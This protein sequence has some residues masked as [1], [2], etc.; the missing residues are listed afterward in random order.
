M[1]QLHDLGLV[2]FLYTISLESI[3]GRHLP[4]A[5]LELNLLGVD[6]LLP[7]PWIIGLQRAGDL[8]QHIGTAI[9]R[10]SASDVENS[11]NDWRF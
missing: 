3:R 6:H 2:L 5:G 11:L 1:Q 9:F 10:K 4:F 7:K 8:F